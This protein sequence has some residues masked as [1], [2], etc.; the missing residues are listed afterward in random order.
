MDRNRRQD[1]KTVPRHIALQLAVATLLSLTACSERPSGP[2]DPSMPPRPE[3]ASG[4]V[5]NA[6]FVLPSRPVS[7]SPGWM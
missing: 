1:R 4:Y 5:I 7:P 6:N 3:T 2:D